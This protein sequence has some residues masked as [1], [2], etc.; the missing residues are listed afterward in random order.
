MSATA[1]VGREDDLSRL[2]AAF[3]DVVRD[4][5]AGLVTV[6]GSPGLGKSRLAGEVVALLAT[7]ALVIEA[8]CTPSGRSSFGPIVDA[9]RLLVDLD[10]SAS[11]DVAHRAVLARTAGLGVDADRVAATVAA[12]LVGSPPGSAEQVFWSLRR[13]V[14]ALAQ[15]T[16]VVMLVDDVHWAEPA[17]LDLIEHLAEW[18]RGPVLILALARP[19]LR[20]RRPSLVEVGGPSDLVVLLGPLDVDAAQRMALDLLATDAIPPGVLARA[21]DASEGNPLFLRE[22]LRL[23]V[24][25]GVLRRVDDE[26]EATVDAGGIELPPTIHAALAARIEQL[27]PA[28]RSVL[29]TASIIGRHFARGAL[30]ELVSPEVGADLEVHLDS[31]RRRELVDAEGTWWADD[32]MFR[33]HHALIRDAAYRRVLKEV[34]ADLHERYSEWLVANV[35][36]ATVEHDEA[37]GYHLEQAHQCRVELGEGDSDRTRGLAERAAAHLA[38]A[39][40]RALDRDDVASA[41]SLLGRVL[42]LL[43]AEDPRR[44]ALSRERCDALIAGG[45]TD[46][47]ALVVSDLVAAASTEH[48][49]AIADV[50]DARLAALR[51]SDTLRSIADHARRA[52]AVLSAHDDDAGLAHAELVLADALVSLGQVG[53]CEGALDRA[54]AAARR[55]GDRRLSNRVLALAPLA[56]L[57]GPSPVKRA[58]GRCLDLIRVLRITSWAPL[59]EAHVHHSQAV[60]EALRDRPEAS[61]QWLESAR[62]TFEELGQHLGLLDIEMHAGLVELLAEQPAVAEA[63]LR[64][65]RDGYA[66]LGSHRRGCA[67]CS[68]TGRALVDLDRLDEAETVA[69]AADGG[70]DIQATIGL[71]GVRSELLVR[72]GMFDDAEALARQAVEI[73]AGTDALLDHA[74]ARV[75]LS[76]TRSQRLVAE[77]SRARSSPP[78]SL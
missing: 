62:A 46:E 32:R 50:F 56:Q 10:D 34:R 39:A 67:C 13:F 16:P 9:L 60:L 19:E 49:A 33:F 22:L 40:N 2:L 63:H 44:G 74:D 36:T 26:W 59:V 6:V 28:E 30:L 75:S 29:E 4:G 42:A 38:A 5:R 69:D 43:P 24:D 11:A 17:L 45:D 76:R 1:F 47:A 20:E 64:R 55:V 8:R 52:A 51:S 27:R 12:L 35:G 31:L 71:L 7:R 61:R 21:V 65:A 78:R 73:A 18:A 25:D 15:E 66:A 3:G 58:S 72:R 14:E 70:D 53:A 77:R 41:A 48:E 23:L 37:L 68:C 54:L 57:W